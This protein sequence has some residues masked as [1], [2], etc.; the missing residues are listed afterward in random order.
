ML[1]LQHNCRKT[2]VV[3]IQALEQALEAQAG[4]VCLQEPYRGSIS[5][6]SFVFFWPEIE[7]RATIRVAVAVRRDILGSWAIEHRTDL[8][9]STHAQCLDVW[10][11]HKGQKTQR[12]RLVNVY[13]QR[14]R[15]E[16]G[17]AFRAISKLS[18]SHIITRRTILAGDFNARS[19]RWDPYT[20]R[21]T[22]CNELLELIEKFQLILN[23][24]EEPTRE[25]NESRSVIDLT[26]ST[27]EI[28]LLD[29]WAVDLN[30]PTT[31][32]HKIIYFSWLPLREESSPRRLEK[33]VTGWDIDL[34]ARDP[35]KETKAREN[36]IRLSLANPP[37]LETTDNLDQEAKWIQQALTDVL[38][39]W[40]KPLYITTFSKRWWN[41]DIKKAR[42]TFTSAH[43]RWQRGQITFSEYKEAR[44]SFY[45]LIR[46]EKRHT[47]EQ[48]L[49]G[50]SQ[51]TPL[52]SSKRC[53]AALRYSRP[54]PPAQCTPS[55]IVDDTTITTIEGKREVFL[56]QAFPRQDFEDV[57]IPQERSA[58]IPEKDIERALFSQSTKKAPGKDRLNFKAI[59]LLWNWDCQRILNLIQACTKLGYQPKGWKIA[60]GIILRKPN[61]PINTTPKAYRVISLLNCLGKVVE[62]TIATWLSSWCED[63]NILHNGQFGSRRG[64]STVDALA[65]LVDTV[66]RAWKEKKVVG[67]LMLDVKG[68]FDH[69]NRKRL[70]ELLKELGLPGNIIAWVASFLTDRQACLVVD[71][72]EGPLEDI[73]AGL[74]QGSPVSPILFIIYISKLLKE[75]EERFPSTTIPSFADDICVLVA[76]SSVEEVS[77]ALGEIG[78]SALNLGKEHK[79]EF[80]MKKTEAVLLSRRRDTQRKAKDFPINLAGRSV[81]FNKE[82]TRWLGFWL[83]YKLD[84][85]KH[86][87]KKIVQAKQALHQTRSLVKRKGL[88]IGLAK[89][90]Q[91]AA[92]TSI[93]LYGAEI[94]WRGQKT[95]ERELQTLF[96]SQARAALGLFKSTPLRFLQEESGIPKAEELLNYRQN[97]FTL[98]ALQKPA[99]HPSNDL[100]PSTFRFG[101]MDAQPG[102][103]SETNL[104]WEK[105]TRQ[106]G[107]G[108]HLAQQLTKVLEVNL[109]EGLEETLFSSTSLRGKVI[110]REKNLAKEDALRVYPE[111]LVLFSDGAKDREFASAGV[112]WKK[113]QATTFRTRGITLGRGKEALDAELY[114]IREALLIARKE[115]RESRQQ[116][117]LIRIFTDC[118][119]A[120]S[121][122]QERKR[123]K[124][125]M[126]VEILEASNSLTIPIVFSWVPAHMEVEGNVLADQA[127]KAVLGRSGSKDNVVSTLYVLKQIKGTKKDI[128]LDPNIL[129]GKRSLT[130]RYL[131]LKSAHACVGK[132]LKR[133]KAIEDESCPWCPAQVETVE[134]A[135]LSCKAW[136][137]GRNKLL[138]SVAK[139]LD[140]DLESRNRPTQVSLDQLFLRDVSP[141]LLQFLEDES[142]GQRGE[143]EKSRRLDL[144]DLQLLDPGGREESGVEEEDR[145]P[146]R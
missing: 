46:R 102:Q 122:L 79:I 53:W 63:N 127:A 92:V 31:S 145:T 15:P 96:N 115:T 121:I 93:A 75:L 123:W 10:E 119:K 60:K 17:A 36:W 81:P 106:R 131:Q 88:A 18:W 50:E 51:E 111:D 1:V 114:A 30:N 94:W 13:D 27:P 12:T 20:R 82:A 62:K 33:V 97:L 11:R 78:D 135:L 116:P 6:P 40:A 133:I 109:E 141:N 83:D 24:T 85:S 37:I 4:I 74:P 104:D 142:I 7:D 47:W 105:D 2:Y 143:R 103:Y 26:F 140:L 35:I 9:N 67:A 146:S 14:I 69:V 34:L 22:N 100:L 19:P 139:K 39:S 43:H 130:T 101:E 98:R 28:G 124:S 99:F 128:A 68:A 120:L 21:P 66:E 41:K 113:Q 91:I 110:I 129:K 73:Q 137:K 61:K 118:K 77:V 49:E 107:L 52:D 45:I 42:Q 38:N 95:R 76:G 126:V 86:F 54:R 108:K 117:K 112:A 3:S 48:F 70:L 44:N 56:K 8:V 25:E 138:K 80:E 72:I 125:A 59:R 144:W 57:I 64:R 5:H 87:N 55:L 32:D 65:M 16:Q 90:V 58:T 84:F 71:G 29:H 89:R 134:H 23:N 132:H 136:R